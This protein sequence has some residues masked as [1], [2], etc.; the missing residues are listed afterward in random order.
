MKS[1]SQ[2]RTV[3]RASSR[4]AF[5][6]HRRSGWARLA[7]TLA[8]P[9]LLFELVNAFPPSPHHTFYGTVRDERGNP[10]R[11]DNAKVMFQTASGRILSSN[12]VPGM[13][14]GQNY[15]LRIPMDA[16]LTSD[17]Y[18]PSAM[19]PMMPFTIRVRIGREV[20]LPIEINSVS[21]SIGEP[22]EKT[23]LD[24]TLGEDLDGDGIPDAWE[25]SL[26]SRGLADDLEGVDPNADADG[27]GLSNIDEYMAGSYAF[28]DTSGFDL[29]LKQV[30]DGVAM[31]EFLSIPGRTYEVL[32]STDLQQWSEVDFGLDS[33]EDE[34]MR[35][36]YVADD[37]RIVEI[38]VPSSEDGTSYQ[39]FKLKV[40]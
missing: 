10:V 11:A 40:N 15:R 32:G 25:R 9:F 38:R 26:I 16:G 34:T 20:F 30:V 7:G 35:S 8:I 31:M 5:A 4:A 28:D 33:D 19:R 23:Q 29:V 12:I 1:I 13:A 14:L 39:F 2:I 22:G 36:N 18:K 6:K 17:L 24:L 21:Q 27:D 37:V 3:G